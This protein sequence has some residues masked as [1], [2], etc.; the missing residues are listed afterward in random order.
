VEPLIQDVLAPRV[1]GRSTITS[2]DVRP[3]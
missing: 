1:E 3:T 2:D